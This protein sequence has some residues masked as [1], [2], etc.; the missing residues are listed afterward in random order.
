MT[1]AS[2]TSRVSYA[3]NGVT[4]AF[5]FP[6]RFLADADLV[7]ISVNDTTGAETSQVLTTNYTVTGAGAVSGGTVTMLSAPASGTTLVIYRDPAQLQD[8]DLSDNDSFPAEEVE[9]RL[10]KLTMLLQRVSN[11]VSRAIRLPEGY[12]GAFDGFLPAI[13]TPLTTPQVNAAGDGF[14]LVT[15]A[16][17]GAVAVP[18]AGT[19]MAVYTGSSTFIV[20]T[21]TPGSGIAVVNGNG[22]SGNPTVSIPAAGVVKSMLGTDARDLT[23]ITKTSNFTLLGTEDLALGD[24]AS[25]AFAYTL[26]S[27]ASCKKPITIENIGAN[28][29]TLSGAGSDTIEGATSILLSKKYDRITLGSNGVNTFYVLTASIA[30]TVQKLT[31]GTAA[32]YTTPSGVKRLRV[33]L[34]AGGGGGGGG[35]GN[36]GTGGT[37][38]FGSSLLSAT[39][40]SGGF[41]G[42]LGNNA[43]GGGGAGSVSAPAV[44]FGTTGSGGGAGLQPNGIA[45]AFSGGGGSSPFGGAGRGQAGATANGDSAAA[46]SGSGGTGGVSSSSGLGCGGGGGAGGYVDAY[47]YNPSA[48]YTY[49]V[50]AAGTAGASGGVV[51]GGAGGDGFIVVEEFYN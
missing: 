30:P 45:S 2:T 32:T 43:G 5:S 8:L 48:T 19:G 47:I 27:A 12:S 20:R 3:G 23:V 35:G 41:G 1:V 42:T 25:G 13:L 44:G 39:G 26:P 16:S 49:T 38:S 10:D 33:R 51:S 15:F 4:T 21:L 14:D 28:V 18:G 6:Y 40:G 22:Q 7:V 29:L 37:T 50:G 31:S 46:N 17:Q 24:T 9:K 36:G 34:V 11:L